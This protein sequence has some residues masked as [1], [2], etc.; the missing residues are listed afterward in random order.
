MSSMLLSPL[1]VFADGD[2]EETAEV[3]DPIDVRA[4][5]PRILLPGLQLSGSSVINPENSLD[6]V[7]ISSPFLAQYLSALYRFG[8]GASVV[9]CLV[10]LIISGFQWVISGG[11]A[12][13]IGEAKGRI[14]GALTGMLLAVGSYLV[15]YTIN[16]NL[17]RFQS[18]RVFY[19]Q[20]V[21][22][23]NLVI[24]DRDTPYGISAG[25]AQKLQDTTF[26]DVFKAF[27]N[28]P[29]GNASGVNWK[30][31]KA[32]AHLESGFN[33]TIVNKFGFTGLFQIGPR[34]CNAMMNSYPLWSPCGAT[35]EE[36]Q[37]RLKDPVFNTAVGTAN[38]HSNV[39]I[40]QKL[41]PQTS[42]AYQMSMLAYFAHNSGA[43]ALNAV[44]QDNDEACTSVEA[45]EQ[46]IVKYWVNYKT[47]PQNG[48][49]E[50]RA[51][52]R[53]QSA[54]HVAEL[55]KQ[56]GMTNFFDTS[57][58][59]K[60]ACPLTQAPS[61]FVWTKP[62]SLGSGACPV[63]NPIVC[64]TKGRKII[65]IGDSMTAPSQYV[66]KLAKACNHVILANTA[67]QSAKTGPGFGG[68][69]SL[70]EQLQQVLQSPESIG[71]Q[72]LIVL[73]GANDIASGSAVKKTGAQSPENN[74]LEIY[75]M[76]KQKGLR[77][78]AITMS[79]WSLYNNGSSWDAAREERLNQ[80][81]SWI[82][83][84][85]P[86]QTGQTYIDVVVDF[87]AIAKDPTNDDAIC[88]D[89]TRDGIHLNAKGASVLA[90]LIAQQAY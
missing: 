50:S 22:L 15:L 86:N 75:G 57:D 42:D 24:G 48:T 5:T 35:S 7:Y 41:C 17:V 84:K 29:V 52:T 39:K 19:V 40:I 68:P 61:A 60:A 16:P 83:K 21:D 1:I 55:G 58:N 49:P 25:T 34:F 27:A 11:N 20:G 56:L 46:G 37:T 77:V 70:K 30:Y 71:A 12:G 31:L 74:L 85:G 13:V 18:L 72:D 33:H 82:R 8:V 64:D 67:V 6:D 38:V 28:C 79:P 51:N 47:P 89:L 43:G 32:V 63:P 88:A 14:A 78:I 3:A 9:V 81:N 87:Y 90:E 53:K 45:L 69:L 44:I 59:G 54:K 2:E 66:E 80:L 23:A 65:A 76:A 26:D 4:P 36:S 10:I 73:G 62:A